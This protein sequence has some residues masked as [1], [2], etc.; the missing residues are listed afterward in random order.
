M[1]TEPQLMESAVSAETAQKA[2]VYRLSSADARTLGL[3]AAN[4]AN[5]SGLA[6][7]YRHPVTGQVLVTRIRPDNAVNGCKYLAPIGSRNHLYL[8]FATEALLTDA[9]FAVVLTEGEKKTLAL[10]EAAGIGAHP[11]KRSDPSPIAL[12]QGP[13]RPIVDRSKILTGSLG[14]IDRC[15][16]SL[17]LT[18][19]RILMCSAPRRRSA[20]N[21]GA[22]GR[23]RWLSRCR[24]QRTAASRALTTFSR[25]TRPVR[26]SRPSIDSCGPQLHGAG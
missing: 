11:T 20:G 7:P 4:T 21:C 10:A 8:P 6:F 9:R 18:A 19:R 24:R 13:S 12:V 14:G 15:S 25:D 22:A 1:A 2:G 17:I 23:L 3:L 26:G 16:S 5:L